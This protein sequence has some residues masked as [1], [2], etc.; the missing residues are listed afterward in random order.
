MLT[1]TRYQAAV[2]GPDDV[3]PSEGLDAR[4]SPAPSDAPSELDSDAGGDEAGVLL[5]SSRCPTRTTPVPSPSTSSVRPAT[6]S[7]LAPSA[8][9]YVAVPISTYTPAPASTVTTVTDDEMRLREAVRTLATPGLHARITMPVVDFLAAYFGPRIGQ[10]RNAAELGV[11]QALLQ[12]QSLDA[13][14][15]GVL[16]Q[17]YQA[18]WIAT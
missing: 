2:R 17:F 11:V 6:A 1:S 15:E 13:K 16:I 14:L 18:F 3:A 4:S 9:A 12:N 8:P 7:A 10:T 5:R